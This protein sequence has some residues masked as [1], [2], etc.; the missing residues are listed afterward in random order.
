MSWLGD[1]VEARKLQEDAEKRRQ[2]LHL[3]R[4]AETWSAVRSMV[5][6]LLKEFGTA[7]W[8]NR[9]GRGWFVID[10]TGQSWSMVWAGEEGFAVCLTTRNDK[11]CFIISSKRYEF[12]E[13]PDLSEA[14][15]KQ[16]LREAFVIGPYQCIR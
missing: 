12:I 13:T 15:L 14:A 16:G 1:L 6:R 4:K 5:K 2:E 10:E 11:W 8:A 7:Y 9:K 3:R